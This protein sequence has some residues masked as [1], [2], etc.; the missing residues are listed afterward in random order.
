MSC[1]SKLKEIVKKIIKAI[2][3]L[4]TIALLAAAAYFFWWSAPGML[5]PLAGV[6]WLPAWAT[7]ASASATTWG[8]AALG[9]ALVINPGGVG[10]LMGEAA[11]AVGSVAGRVTTGLAA[12]V[13]TG[14]TGALFG[15]SPT[16]L[17]ATGLL[18]YFFVFSDDSKKNRDAVKDVLPSSRGRK[19][20]ARG[21]VVTSGP[22]VAAS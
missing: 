5:T 17:I 16:A 2:K 8:V 10:D 18:L 7:T 21:D 20:T 11:E 15:M 12:G 13:A 22:S 4:L 6:S 19:E 9:A 1:C 14:V 3:P